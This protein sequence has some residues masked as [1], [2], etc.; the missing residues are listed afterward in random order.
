M[1]SPIR[2]LVVDDSAVVRQ[3]LVDILESDPDIEVVGTASDPFVAV[4]KLRRVKPDVITLDVEMPRM[5]GVTFLRK[6]MSQSPIPVVICSSL[7]GEGTETQIKAL[8]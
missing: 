4:D 2:V 1:T 7:V 5:D 3:T 6:L 8:E